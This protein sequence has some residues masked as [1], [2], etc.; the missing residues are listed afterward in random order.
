M[1]VKIIT[2]ICLILG[3]AP[4]LVYPFVLLANVMS[5]AAEPTGNKKTFADIAFK[6][7]L[8]SSTLYPV[9]FVPLCMSA[10]R[11]MRAGRLGFGLGIATIPVV[12]LVVIFVL[13]RMWDKQGAKK[14][15]E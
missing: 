10:I 9:V 6:G 15:E 4:L 14:T 7:F 13:Y 12:L 5:L 1:A 11:L 3:G 2:Y 8:W